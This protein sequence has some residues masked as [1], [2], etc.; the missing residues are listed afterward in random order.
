M[1]H[2]QSEHFCRVLIHNLS[3]ALLPPL[4]CTKA[5][6]YDALVLGDFCQNDTI[7][8]P[9]ERTLPSHFP[10]QTALPTDAS[11][12]IYADAVHGRDTNSGTLT[13]PVQTVARAVALTRGTK[14]PATVVLRAG[15]YYQREA[16]QLDERDSHLTLQ[17]YPGEAAWLSGG[18]HL[19]GLQWKPHAVDGALNVFAADVSAF[20]LTRVHG[21]RVNERRVSPARYPDADP[22][23]Q[24]WPT[25]WVPS[26]AA[27]W[28]PP[29][30]APKPNPAQIVNVSSPNRDWDDDFPRYTGGEVKAGGRE[31]KGELQAK[32]GC[33]VRQ[34]DWTFGLRRQKERRAAREL[35]IS[36]LQVGKG[37]RLGTDQL[38]PSSFRRAPQL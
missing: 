5:L 36:S 7:A 6:I 15:T 33:F 1:L 14:A 38:A 21:L 9:D 13:D 16:V 4:A 37:G 18:V 32:G 2:L 11:R 8:R 31:E 24:F 34:R 12:T 22:E 27:D 35:Y 25:G 26:T 29:A 30:I 23:T 3:C 17:N 20:N 19:T 10:P 28:L